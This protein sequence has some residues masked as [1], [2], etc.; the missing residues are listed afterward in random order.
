MSDGIFDFRFGICD[1][2]G[3]SAHSPQ[4]SNAS[5]E[6]RSLSLTPRFSG[7]RQLIGSPNRFSGFE[8]RKQTAEAVLVVD[9]RKITPLKRSV[10]ERGCCG[11]PYQSNRKSQMQ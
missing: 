2:I 8:S 1:W 3:R 5:A 10:N 6:P 7:V 9:Q 4:F 11:A